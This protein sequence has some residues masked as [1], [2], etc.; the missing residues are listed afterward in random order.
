[1]LLLQGG[2]AEKN[3]TL[4][5]SHPDTWPGNF[6]KDPDS[7]LKKIPIRVRPPKSDLSADLK[8]LQPLDFFLGQNLWIKIFL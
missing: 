1:M 2:M 8:D 6:K 5:F 7:T 3:V 4:T